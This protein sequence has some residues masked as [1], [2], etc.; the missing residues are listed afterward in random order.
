M[1]SMG[2]GSEGSEVP[3]SSAGSSSIT[4]R[5]DSILGH[6]PGLKV[7]LEKL[8]LLA[9]YLAASYDFVDRVWK[10][11]MTLEHAG[12][13]DALTHVEY[14]K[15]VVLNPGEVGQMAALRRKLMPQ[16]RRAEIYWV[17]VDPEPRH[18]L[19]AQLRADTGEGADQ[20]GYSLQKQKL[21]RMEEGTAVRALVLGDL[22]AFQL[23][24]LICDAER[25][26]RRSG[27]R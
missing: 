25:R 1:R 22:F 20:T 21:S 5:M 11:V 26:A 13:L 3:P 9:P 10:I 19:L 4:D 24:A 16:L 14:G 7:I 2:H 18:D 15:I 8:F 12:A 6:A 27:K 23:Y 17:N